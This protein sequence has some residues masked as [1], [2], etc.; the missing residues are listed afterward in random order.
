LIG[1]VYLVPQLQGAGLA[2]SRILPTPVWVGAVV[3]AVLVGFNVFAGGMRA[4]TV[5]QAFQ[6][7]LKLVTIAVPTFVLCAVFLTTGAGGGYGLLG[8]PAPPVFHEP[9]EVRVDTAVTL[10][11]GEPT[12]LRA[13]GTVDG[14]PADGAVYWSPAVSHQVAAGT[15]LW[16]DEDTRVP[17]L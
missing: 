4:V 17:V 5:V 7:W 14:A 12:G 16:F 9:T 8:K 15:T 6:Y 1:V 2:L 13:S 11:V 3:V 10:T